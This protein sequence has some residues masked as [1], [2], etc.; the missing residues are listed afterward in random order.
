VRR[1][2]DVDLLTVAELV[3]AEFPK[4]GRRLRVAYGAVGGSVVMRHR[5]VAD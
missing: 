4:Q 3:E 5:S 2:D 1:R